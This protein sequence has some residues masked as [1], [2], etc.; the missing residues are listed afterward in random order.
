MTPSRQDSHPSE[1]GQILYDAADPDYR[2]LRP[3]VRESYPRGTLGQIARYR[4]AEVVG[5]SGRISQN[6]RSEADSQ[7][8]SLIS[9][10]VV[11]Q[12]RSSH[13]LCSKSDRAVYGDVLFVFASSFMTQKHL[14]DFPTDMR[15]GN[16]AAFQCFDKFSRFH[17]GRFEII[18]VK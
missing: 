4:R 12:S 5:I 18:N 3:M 16:D 6:G 9:C 2:V 10:L 13:I 14:P 1:I 17:D 8:Q 7:A 15:L 11:D